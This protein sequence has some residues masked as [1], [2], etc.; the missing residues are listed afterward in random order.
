MKESYRVPSSTAQIHTVKS[1]FA[2]QASQT[3]SSFAIMRKSVTLAAFTYCVKHHAVR[4][5][6]TTEWSIEYWISC[7]A[8]RLSA[9]DWSGPETK[10]SRSFARKS[11][12]SIHY[13]YGNIRR[14]SFLSPALMSL[15]LAIGHRKG[16]L[17]KNNSDESWHQHATTQFA[18]RRSRIGI[19]TQPD[20]ITSSPDKESRRRCARIDR[21]AHSQPVSDCGWPMRQPRFFVWH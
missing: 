16:R 6:A 5:T 18:D 10:R 19:V 4:C 20:P 7:E 17:G 3:T 1:A 21:T 9:F 15:N 8:R 11:V 13:P 14:P 2:T 12:R